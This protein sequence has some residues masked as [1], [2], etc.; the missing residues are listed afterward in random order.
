[1]LL[2]IIIINIPQCRPLST[3]TLTQIRSCSRRSARNRQQRLRNPQYLPSYV[4]QG[5]SN[6]HHLHALQQLSNYFFPG[7]KGTVVGVETNDFTIVMRQSEKGHMVATKEAKK[8]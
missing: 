1:M 5:F 6:V 4:D 8:G 3:Y 7:K 2:F